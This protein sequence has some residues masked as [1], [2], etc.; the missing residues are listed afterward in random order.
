MSTAQLEQ[1]IL[2]A[3]KAEGI[4]P[5]PKKMFGGVAFMVKDHMSVGITNKGDFM[6]RFDPARHEEI[7]EWPGAKPMTFGKPGSKGFVFVDPDAVESD[8]ALQKWIKLSLDHISKLPPKA[9]KKAA[10]KKAAKKKAGKKKA[11]K[12]KAAKKKA[13]KKAVSN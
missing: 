1:R 2:H 11:S 8:A 13:K 5:E 9:K 6:A 10:A 7:M 4:D 12:K 3:L